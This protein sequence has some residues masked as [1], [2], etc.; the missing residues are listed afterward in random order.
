MLE[1][2]DWV[3]PG[4]FLHWVGVR[5]EYGIGSD[6][7]TWGGGG[8]SHWYIWYIATNLSF[9]I[10]ALHGHSI[11]LAFFR[12]A[13]SLMPALISMPAPTT[14]GIQPMQISFRGSRYTGRLV[15]TTVTAHLAFLIPR[16]PDWGGA[17]GIFYCSFNHMLVVRPRQWKTHEGSLCLLNEITF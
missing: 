17:C 13:N 4:D 9:L 11:S 2:T 15:I 6:E 1:N 12:R 7:G 8:G 5:T 14:A 16:F 10:G 3:Q